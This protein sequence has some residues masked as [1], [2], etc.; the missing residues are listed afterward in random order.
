[1][2]FF[3]ILKTFKEIEKIEFFAHRGPEGPF[4]LNSNMC[5][6]FIQRGEFLYFSSPGIFFIFLNFSRNRKKLSFRHPLT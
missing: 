2:I 3:S 1:M 6:F 5:S 4:C